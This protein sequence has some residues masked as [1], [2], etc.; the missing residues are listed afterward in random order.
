VKNDDQEID[1]EVVDR[2]RS[3]AVEIMAEGEIATLDEAR[4]LAV[5]T[6]EVDIERQMANVERE[7]YGNA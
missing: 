6:A 4:A 5:E 7:S 1:D 2:E 3:L